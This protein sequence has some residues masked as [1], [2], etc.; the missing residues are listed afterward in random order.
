MSSPGYYFFGARGPKLIAAIITYA[1]VCFLLLG[2]DQGVLSGVLTNPS[3]L[4]AMG[5]PSN[6]MIGTV[7][8]IYDVG[9]WLGAMLC[10]IFGEKIGRKRSAYLG[11]GTML[12]GAAIQTASYSAAQMLVGRI[13]TGLGMG[14]NGATF[15]MWAAEMVKPSHR[16]R[17]L[18]A[19]GSSVGFGIFFSYWF[20]YGLSYV[21]APASWRVPVALQMLFATVSLSMLV[22]LPESPRWLVAHDRLE[23][24]TGVLA[25][26]ESKTADGN[27]PEVVARR[28]DIVRALELEHAQGP[29]R[30]R[31]LFQNNE[32][33]NRRRFFLAIGIQVFQQMSGVNARKSQEANLLVADD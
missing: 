2:Y 17:L 29:V 9:A 16:G 27:T 33:K 28:D 32:T 1:A 24:A 26:V 19:L 3:F 11:L 18:S 6:S 31:E 23:E 13:I 4:D 7:T 8:A 12:I 22:F 20:E 30:W 5:H 25:A 14:T 10:S 15:P 21:N